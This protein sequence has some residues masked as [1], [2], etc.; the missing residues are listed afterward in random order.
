MNPQPRRNDILL[1]FS[2]R[3]LWWGHQ[4][5]RVRRRRRLIATRIGRGGV[6][7][8]PLGRWRSYDPDNRTNYWQVP[9]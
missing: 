1:W 3:G 2:R 5:D 7:V 6:I 4:N 8:V 9:A